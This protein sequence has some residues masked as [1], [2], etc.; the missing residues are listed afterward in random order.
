MRKSKYTWLSLA[1][2]L[3]ICMVAGCGTNETED[4]IGS[5]VIQSETNQTVSART[6]KTPDMEALEFDEDFNIADCYITN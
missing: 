6:F 2:F 1:G 4:A 3:V 5:S